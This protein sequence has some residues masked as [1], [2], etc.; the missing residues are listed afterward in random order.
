M[1]GFQVGPALRTRT[2][3]EATHFRLNGRRD[4]LIRKDGAHAA[5]KPAYDAQWWFGE[6]KTGA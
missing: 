5:A 6:T 4:V 1:I 3:Y 2:E